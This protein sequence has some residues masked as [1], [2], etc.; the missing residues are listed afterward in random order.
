MRHGET[1][2]NAEG[3]FQGRRDPALSAL[4]RR[5]ARGNGEK[6]KGHL[7]SPD[8]AS[9]GLAAY[10]SP[11]RRSRETMELVLVQL[12]IPDARFNTDPRLME[13]SFGCWEGLTTL[14]V[15]ERF[16][17]ERRRRKADRWNFR[18]GGGHSYAELS[19]WMKEFLAD[20]RPRAPTLVVTHAGNMRVMLG[21][22]GGLAPSETM[23]LSIP[24]D[25]VLHWNGRSAVWI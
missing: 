5:Q 17:E 18:P 19:A 21:L 25:A 6:L 22:L 3:R 11:L 1:R 10:A 15:K 24:H 13:A 7:H 9:D 2:W 23:A 8:P 12:G 4:G 14:E 16:P 20:L